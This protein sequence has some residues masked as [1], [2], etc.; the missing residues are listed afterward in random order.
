MAGWRDH[1]KGA[2][3]VNAKCTPRRFYGDFCQ[4]H[5]SGLDLDTYKAAANCQDGLWGVRGTECTL[6]GFFLIVIIQYIQTYMSEMI[7]ERQNSN[8]E[9][10]HDLFSNLLS[11]NDEDLDVTNLT[12][13]ELMGMLWFFLK[14]LDIDPFVNLEGNIYMF[15][16]AGHEVCQSVAQHLQI[17]S[18]GIKSVN[19]AH[20][21]LHLWFIS[22]IPRW[23]G[24]ALQAY[25]ICHSRWPHSGMFK[26]FLATSLSPRFFH[27]SR[28]TKRCHC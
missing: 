23:T 16:L 20:P 7:E 25:P 19:G 26:D 1:T 22:A 11:A 6:H 13:R 9:Q 12:K 17:N 27:S 3:D 18:F 24:K 10:R 28:H 21:L 4:V 14:W 2:P 15:L 5:A 8:K